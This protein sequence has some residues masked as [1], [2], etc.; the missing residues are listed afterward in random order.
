MSIFNRL[1]IILLSLALLVAAGAILL[2]TLGI[3]EP[4]QLAL[5]SWI[6]DRL[7]PFTTLSER[8]Q[9]VTSAVCGGLLVIGLLLLLFELKPPGD[10]GRMTLT[11]DARGRV[12]VKRDGIAALADRETLQ[13]PG[14]MESRAR[15]DEDGKRVRIRERVSVERGAQVAATTEAIRE[16]VKTAVEQHV[17]K[18]VADVRVDAQLEPLDRRRRVR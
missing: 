17:G 1:L 13:I 14:V 15:V 6:E 11:R 3:V 8:D 7:E 10:D 18:P 2:V 12:T 5:T 9:I 16:R 4:A